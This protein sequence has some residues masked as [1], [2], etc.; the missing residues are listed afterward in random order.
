M[1]EKKEHKK[2]NGKRKKLFSIF[3]LVIAVSG[4]V[5]AAYWFLYARNYVSTDN[6]YVAAEMA[7]V[8]PSIGGTV[9]SINVIDT[10]KVKAGDVLVVLEASDAQLMLEQ[11]V[12]QLAQ[13]QTNLDRAKIDFDRRQ[14]LAESGSVSA[15]EITN[16]ENAYKAAQ[17]TFNVANAKV[18][19]A[20]IDLQRTTI[21]API[22]GVVAK[23]SV[24]LGQRVQIGSPLLS[25]V[26][27]DKVH[28]DANFKEVQLR[29]VKIGQKVELE[30]DLY[31]GKVKYHGRVA[32]FSGGTGAAFAIIPAQNATGNWIKVVQRLPVRIDLDPKE[33]AEHPLQ[34]GLSMH[35][36][37]D[38]SDAH[39]Q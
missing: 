17:A 39:V 8:A 32:G 33:L 2:P 25:I 15:E 12:A 10:Q 29:N 9:Q 3:F 14:S 28:V 5:F 22:D 37:I 31:G 6:A 1:S 13:T 27:L 21:V 26:P 35:A 36:T 23:R 16:A 38:I 20:K 24:Q 4:G 11:A 30:S 18:N 34:V 7:Q 19:Q